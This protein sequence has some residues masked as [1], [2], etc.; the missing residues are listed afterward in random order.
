[1]WLKEE[2]PGSGDEFVGE[3]SYSM[4]QPVLQAP[5]NSPLNSVACLTGGISPGT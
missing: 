2:A 4:T 5:P 1:M 3:P